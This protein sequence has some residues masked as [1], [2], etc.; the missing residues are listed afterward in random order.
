ME[1][2]SGDKPEYLVE[3]SSCR[4]SFAAAPHPFRPVCEDA[5]LTSSQAEQ[6]TATSPDRAVH[7]ARLVDELLR[8]LH[9]LAIDR[10][11]I[12]T[13]KSS[14]TLVDVPSLDRFM[15]RSRTEMRQN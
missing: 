15:Q 3:C 13:V 10:R 1:F 9:A 6:T 5:A 4:A 12:S 2:E 11:I 7:A 8:L 14:V